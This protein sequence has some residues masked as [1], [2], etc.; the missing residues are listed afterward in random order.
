LKEVEQRVAPAGEHEQAAQEIPEE[1]WK[2][3][4]LSYLAV[5]IAKRGDLANPKN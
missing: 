5:Q 1:E 2:A 4:A 3:P